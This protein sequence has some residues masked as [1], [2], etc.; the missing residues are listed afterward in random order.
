MKRVLITGG[1]GFVARHLA[2]LLLQSNN[3]IILSSR[4]S[5]ALENRAEV[6]AFIKKIRPDQIY[7]LAALSSPSESWKKE[8]E[9]YAVNIGGTI[10]L[11]EAVRRYSP[12]AKLLLASSVHVYGQTLAQGRVREDSLLHPAHPYGGSKVL[13]ELACR[14]L[15]HQCHLFII[16]ARAVNHLGAGQRPGFVFSDWCRQI[17]LAERGRGPA[18]LRVGNLDIERDFLHVEDVVS[19]YRLLMK[20]AAS[21]SVY[22]VSSGKL[23]SL[24]QAADFLL[25]RAKVKM[26]IIKETSRYRAGEAKKISVENTPLRRL[27]WRPKHSVEQGLTDLL[28][29]WRERLR[30][31]SNGR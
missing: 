16:I 30:E 14:Q 5:C 26:K 28:T 31:R 12:H 2:H 1:S 7:H 11:L 25:R 22:N 18:E 21:G 29:D 19:A 27:G 23:I 10:H 4:T 8:S 13:A 15:S 24:S 17:A 20:R 3:K 9:T 6:A